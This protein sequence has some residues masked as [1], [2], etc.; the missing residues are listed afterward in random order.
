MGNLPLLIFI[1]YSILT[2]NTAYYCKGNIE[3][4][5]RKITNNYFKTEFKLDFI[6][7]LPLIIGNVLNIG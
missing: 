2:L 1:G 5:R 7:I 3:T 4:N 6:T